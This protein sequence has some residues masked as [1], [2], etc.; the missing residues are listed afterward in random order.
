MNI[1]AT[2][3]L[4]ASAIIL[5]GTLLYPRRWMYLRNRTP[6]P[7]ADFLQ[8]TRPPEEIKAYVLGIRRAV[9]KTCRIAPEDI[10]PDDKMRVLANLPLVWDHA[11]IIMEFE[12]SLRI[13]LADADTASLSDYLLIKKGETFGDWCVSL[14]PRIKAAFEEHGQPPLRPERTILP[15][16]FKIGS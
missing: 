11:G 9:A 15:T 2:I 13:Y 10:R 14:A 8:A 6:M 5:V 12:E 7:D 4:G 3:V 16:F 1:T